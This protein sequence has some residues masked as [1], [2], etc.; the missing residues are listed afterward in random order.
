MEDNYKKEELIIEPAEIDREKEIIRNIIKT[1]E[2]I[3]RNNKN[4]EFA[5]SDLID[6]YIYEMKANQSKLNYLLKLAKACGI[7]IDSI[8]Q[9]KYQNFEKEVG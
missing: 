4:F 3:K 9:I 2:D 8:E 5:E 6:Y 7:T 1:R